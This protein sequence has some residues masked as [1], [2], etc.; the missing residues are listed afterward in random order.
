MGLLTEQR[1]S[2][3]LMPPFGT[4]CSFWIVSSR[5]S[6]RSFVSLL[7]GIP[8]LAD[9]HGRV[10]CLCRKKNRGGVVGWGWSSGKVEGEAT[11]GGGEN[12]G[13]I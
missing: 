11:S 13:W 12:F 10:A 4:H 3:S 2:L 7:L 8:W 9:I 5:L 6:R 1:L